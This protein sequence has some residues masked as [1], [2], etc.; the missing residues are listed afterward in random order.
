MEGPGQGYNTTLK[1]KKS[2]HIHEQCENRVKLHLLGIPAH[3]Q[4]QIRG[5]DSQDMERSVTFEEGEQAANQPFALCDQ[6]EWKELLSC[7]PTAK[8]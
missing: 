3:Q 6:Q 2:H 1:K 4:R 7:I 8:C 5:Y